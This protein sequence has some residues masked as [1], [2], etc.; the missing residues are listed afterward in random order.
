LRC[1]LVVA[2]LFAS[3]V[4]SDRLTVLGADKKNAANVVDPFL[5][6]DAEPPAKDDISALPARE[7]IP[8]TNAKSRPPLAATPD[9][10]RMKIS[11]AKSNIDWDDESE[12]APKVEAPRV[13]RQISKTAVPKI[14]PEEDFDSEFDLDKGG[15]QAGKSPKLKSLKNSPVGGKSGWKPIGH[16]DSG[17]LEPDEGKSRGPQSEGSARFEREPELDNL[18]EPL[19]DVIIEGNKS[20]KTEQILKQIKTRK[21][22][23]ADPKQIKEDVRT[24]VA[25]RWFFDVETRIAQSKQG[26]VLVF[27]VRERPTI[28]KVTYVGNKKVKLKA[29]NE[30]TGLKEGGGYDVGAN[31]EAVHKIESLYH[32]KGFNHVEVELEKG[33]SP[34]DREIVFKIT[35]GPKVAVTKISFSGNKYFS[36]PVLKT[37]VKTKTRILWYFGGKYDPMSI[38][39]DLNALRQYYHELGFFD[40]QIHDKVGESEDKSQ[41]HIEYVIDEGPRYKIRNVEFVGNHVLKDQQLVDKMKVK[42]NDFYAQRFVNVD[43]DKIVAQYGELGRIFA[44]VEPRTRSFEEPGYVDLVYDINEDRPYRIGRIHVHI[45]GDHPHTKESAVLTKLTFKPG[46]LASMSKI[47]KSKQR[48]SNSQIFAGGRPGGGASGGAPPEITLKPSELAPPRRDLNLA[49]GQ[50]DFTDPPP[51]R[52]AAPSVRRAKQAPAPEPEDEDHEPFIFR[53]QNG[54]QFTGPNLGGQ[55]SSPYDPVIPEEPPAFV[56]PIITLSETQTGRINFGVGINSNAGLLGNAVLEENNFDILRPPTSLQD[57]MDGTAWRGGGQQFRLQAMPGVQVS[58][59]MVSWTDPYFLNQNLMFGVTGQYFMRFYPNW[60]EHRAGG[61]VRVG[62]Q[63]SPTLSGVVTGRAENVQILNP[64]IPTPAQVTAVLGNSFLSTVRGSLI[65]D[66]RDSSFLPGS[67]HYVSLDYEQGIADFVYPKATVE[68]KQYFLVR[69]RPDG[70]NRHVIS[71]NATVGWMGNQAPFFEHFFA[72]GFTTFRGFYFY[73]VTPRENGF[74]VGGNFEALGSVEYLL[75]ITADNTIQIVSF[76]DFGTVDSRVTLDAFRLSVGAGFRLSIPL[77]GP[78]PIAI[79]FAVPI[80]KQPFDT[81][82]VVSF[83]FGLLR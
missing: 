5:E 44:K 60:T 20:F 56:D 15:M 67:G 26:P 72:G 38:A 62:H 63:F 2:T 70:G 50:S 79:D 28:E 4:E 45:N 7:A 64:S 83:S 75:P 41:I 18:T 68:A 23:V 77:M 34:Q 48:L 65:H 32:E 58:S 13:T 21:G 69:E 73:G 22:R 35:E 6:D 66:T 27:R 51:P 52:K 54:D 24:L 19:A 61:N 42:A 46:E 43:R 71:V 17:S 3:G 37:Q 1:L 14:D 12:L 47:E 78:V 76:S 80:M 29:L 10:P 57:I 25:K 9:R 33:G 53:G 39:E 81:T 16:E 59:Y 31:R 30:L 82:Q 11:A 55:D 36:G 49:R 8:G 74:R 40:V